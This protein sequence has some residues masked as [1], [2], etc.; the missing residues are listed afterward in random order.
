M[1]F[2]SLIFLYLFLPLTLSGY[3]LLKNNYRNYWLLFTSLIFFAWGGV[4]YTV[5]LLASLVINYIF[6]LKIQKHTDSKKGYFWLF[7]GV[8]TNLLILCVFKYANFIIIN[9]NN[10]FELFTIPSIPETNIILPIGIS[11]YTF[12]SL[13]YLIDIYRKKTLA[14][15]NI[16][17]LSLYICMFSQ[18][19]AGP[20]IRYSDIWLQLRGRTHTL[21]L[22]SSGVERFLIGLGKKVLLAN[23]FA[24]VADDLFS[25]NVFDL[26]APNAWLGIICYS[27]QIYLDFSG[28][29]DMAIGLGRMFGFNFL[30][31]FNLPY[32]SKSVKEF[33]RRWHIS[34]SSFFRD[35]VYIPLGGNRVKVSRTYLN[36]LFVFFLTGFWHGASW[37]FVV[38][39]LFHGFFMILERL[40]LEKLL[41]R[42]WKPVAN[43]YTILVVMFAWVL[44]RSESLY[45]AFYYW[46]AMLNFQ[47]TNQQYVLFLEHIDKELC[48]AF[49][50]S[51]PG[52]FGFYNYLYKFIENQFSSGLFRVKMFAI[53]LQLISLFFYV[54]ILIVCSMYLIAGSYNPFIYYRF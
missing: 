29:S 10:L 19:I 5:I 8:S 37:S 26:S 40:G 17:D 43:I 36:L 42:I 7:A 47:F 14:Q 46:K 45:A 38:W 12:H 21:A 35:Y 54:S 15:R 4:S 2:S 18:L 53:T 48:I 25:G 20:I 16:F 33:W 32:I 49:I 51:I 13:S 28:Y 52:V 34:L 41:N 31:N 3:Y 6:G 11:F 24:R 22:F 50:V 30:E 1:L 27:L 9:I 23:V 44:F 39:G